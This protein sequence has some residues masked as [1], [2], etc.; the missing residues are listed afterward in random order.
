MRSTL[1]AGGAGPVACAARP[2]NERRRSRL[3]PGSLPWGHA[4]V[5]VLAAVGL[6]PADLAGAVPGHSGDQLAV[7]ADD[8]QGGVAGLDGD[9]A[10]GVRQADV[11]ALAGDLDA[12]AAGHL[13]LDDQPGGW[14]R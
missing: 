7:R 3:L 2:G 4:S 13:P 11:D 12:A 9:D 10:P 8:P 5:G 14:Q 6:E 1:G